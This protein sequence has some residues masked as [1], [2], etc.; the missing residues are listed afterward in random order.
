M[1]GITE[2]EAKEL[3]E[4]FQKIDKARAAIVAHCGGKWKKGAPGAS[5]CIDCPVC[6][7]AGTLRFSRSGYNGHIHAGCVTDNCVAWME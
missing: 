5:G 1:K 4:M 6:G 2:A 7:A 3:E